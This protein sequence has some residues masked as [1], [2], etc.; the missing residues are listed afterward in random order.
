MTSLGTSASYHEEKG[1]VLKFKE[2]ELFG[3]PE[4]FRLTDGAA[5]H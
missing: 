5:I 1:P 4:D 2:L 3:K